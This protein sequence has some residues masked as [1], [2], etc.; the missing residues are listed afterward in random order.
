MARPSLRDRFYTRR[1]AET[2]TSPSGILLAG[3]GVALGVVAGLP[4]VAAAG[5]G[6]LAWGA[7]VAWAMRRPREEGDGFNPFSLSEPWRTFA[8]QA[9]K[10]QRQYEQ[11]VKQTPAGP[12]RAR[13]DTIGGRIA[14]GV[15]ECFRVARS[16]QALVNARAQID[17]NDITR[18]LATLPGPELLAGNPALEQTAE[19]LQ[20]QLDSARRLDTV[21]STTHDR[22]RLLDAQLGEAVTRAIE[23]SVRP[24]DL[25]GLTQLSADVDQVVTEMEALRLALDETDSAGQHTGAGPAAPPVRPDTAPSPST[26]PDRAHGVAEPTAGSP[27]ALPPPVVDPL[28]STPPRP[29]TMPAQAPPRPQ[30]LPAQPPPPAPG[31]FPDGPPGTANR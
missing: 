18:N 24:Q 4:V 17:V 12:L 3:G 29:Q 31:P 5:V 26:A 13:L 25:D 21:I 11:A 20:A 10:A 9:R 8:W 6:A 28:L 27:A 16:G 7:R 14:E 1:V 15:E 19:A 23:L 2:L 22:L 30:T